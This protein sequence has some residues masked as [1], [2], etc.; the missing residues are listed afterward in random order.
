MKTSKPTYKMYLLIL[1]ITITLVAPVAYAQ[2][3][4]VTLVGEINDTNQLI[5]NGELYDIEPTALGEDLAQHYIS[6]KVKVECTV[7]QGEELRIITVKSF[8]TVDE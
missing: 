8:Q 2:S 5:A 4:E 1:F 3:E 7:R 6:M